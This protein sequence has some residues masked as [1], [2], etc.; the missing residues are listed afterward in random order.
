MFV[1][2]TLGG[3]C[4]G[5]TLGWA[6]S[7]VE[8]L[9]E[10]AEYQNKT[11]AIS[12]ISSVMPLG[13]AF[14]T[15]TIGFVMDFLGRKFTMLIMAVGLFLSWLLISFAN[16]VTT[17][18]LG[19]LFNGFFAATYCVLTP[20]Y[21]GECVE[22]HLRGAMGTSFQ[23]LL[24]IG[25]LY[26]YVAGPLACQHSLQ[27]FSVLCCIWPAVFFALFIFKPETPSWLVSKNKPQETIDKS[28]RFLRGKEYDS[29]IEQ[30]EVK[31]AI[32]DARALQKEAGSITQKF[33]TKQAKKAFA[34]CMLLQ[35][36]QQLSG[37]N[38]VI[39]YSQ[40]IFKEAKTDLKP[41]ICTIIF[42]VVQVVA[43]GIAVGIVDR[44]GRKILL[45]ISFVVMAICLIVLGVY[46]AVKED[47]RAKMALVPL[48]ASCVYI[49]GFSIG[50]G[51]LPWTLLGEMFSPEVKGAASSTCACIN[52]LLAFIVTK[53]YDDLN[54]VFGTSTVFWM[55]AG[56]CLLVAF[57]TWWFALE[58]MNKSLEQI[59]WELAG[60][61]QGADDIGPDARMKIAKARVDERQTKEEE[62]KRK[63]DEAAKLAAQKIAQ[64]EARKER[65]R[66]QQEAGLIPTITKRLSGKVA[67]KKK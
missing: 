4:L 5:V 64:E 38:A 41:W 17:Y 65:L 26:A 47:A 28:Y 45:V 23:F 46:F 10:Q 55:F 50:A 39:F 51:P 29:S 18:I 3:F 43:T 48:I 14:S 42:G 67:E 62:V 8:Y 22:P 25:I 35:F 56:V 57:L 30:G 24:V 52:W 31:K 49:F 58:T 36:G 66:Q 6:S 61:A 13:A 60:G 27:R 1:S 40:S 15:I 54:R 32:E 37:I 16:S 12:W 59:Q 2:A 33:R 63:A 44:V 7:G 20:V 53:T 11:E 19:R 34:I 9:K 21:T